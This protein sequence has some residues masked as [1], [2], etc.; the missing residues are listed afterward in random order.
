MHVVMVL[1]HEQAAIALADAGIAV[2]I[3]NSAQVKHFGRELAVR[4]KA[5]GVDSGVIARY[6]ARLKLAAWQPPTHEARA[7]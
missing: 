7:P 4:T 3:I 1:Y 2:S 6:G 5:G